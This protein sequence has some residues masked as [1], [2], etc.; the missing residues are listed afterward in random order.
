MM[1]RGPL[2]RAYKKEGNNMGTYNNP[3]LMK[4][5]SGIFNK[6]SVLTEEQLWFIV[7]YLR[8]LGFDPDE[9]KCHDPALQSNGQVIG[10]LGLAQQSI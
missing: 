2:R 1:D 6:L 9:L 5:V 10:L 7:D 4:L 8:N 3:E